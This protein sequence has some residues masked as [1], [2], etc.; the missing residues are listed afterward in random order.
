MA[1]KTK[2]RGYMRVLTLENG[3]LG[4]YW[5]RFTP[6]EELNI[7]CEHK[8]GITRLQLAKKHEVSVST[9]SRVLKRHGTCPRKTKAKVKGYMR[10]II[11][12]DGKAGYYWYRFTPRE[13]QDIC[14]EYKIGATR[15]QLARKHD[16]TGDTITRVLQRHGRQPVIRGKVRLVDTSESRPGANPRL[17]YFSEK[18]Y[19]NLMEDLGREIRTPTQP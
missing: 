6:N 11:T 15:A 3:R 13:E 9:I 4:S 16:V 17:G 1:G 8:M 18:A 10:A 19:K 5:Y 12:S 14:Y 2:V 7:C